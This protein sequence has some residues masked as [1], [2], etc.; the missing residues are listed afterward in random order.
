[1][2]EQTD[3]VMASVSSSTDTAGTSSWA[4]IVGGGKNDAPG[5]DTKAVV[6]NKVVDIEP[7]EVAA[8][9]KV[10]AS[11][12]KPKEA[13]DP[14]MDELDPAELSQFTEIRNKKDRLKKRDNY[15][16][17]RRG[18]RGGRREH[19]EWDPRPQGERSEGASRGRGKRFGKEAPAKVANGPVAG[20]VEAEV[21]EEAESVVEPEVEEEK[22]QY[23]PAPAPSVNIWEK[24]QGGPPPP[25]PA[26]SSAD[27]PLSGK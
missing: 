15:R 8:E 20:E 11:P 3:V 7:R 1:M 5:D 12:P 23:V 17:G 4:G 6:E 18:G 22:V 24:R 14:P 9:P 19:G 10:A 16:G 2:A 21:V 26:L 13:T 27:P 25:G